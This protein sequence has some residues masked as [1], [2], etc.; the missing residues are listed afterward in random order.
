LLVGQDMLSVKWKDWDELTKL[1]TVVA[2]ARPGSRVRL[3]PK[4]KRLDMPQMDVASSDIRKRLQAGRSI[5]YLV[6]P[7]A[8][9]LIRQ[10]GLYSK[11]GGA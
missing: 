2:A 4:V 1:C 11:Q 5:R 7:A 9:R 10:R 3:S 8:H 6:P